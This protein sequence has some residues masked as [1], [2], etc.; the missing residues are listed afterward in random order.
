[1][2]NNSFLFSPVGVSVAEVLRT[3]TGVSGIYT[4]DASHAVTL[5]RSG[6][7]AKR[8][9]V[10]VSRRLCGLGGQKHTGQSQIITPELGRCL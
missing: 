6:P 2:S 7:V 8:T 3:V 9:R 1:M 10:L 4:D 5:T